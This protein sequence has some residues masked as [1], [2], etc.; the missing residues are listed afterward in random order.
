[1]KSFVILTNF[2]QGKGLKSFLQHK[3]NLG[4]PIKLLNLKFCFTIAHFYKLV[5][6]KKMEGFVTKN[7]PEK[8]IDFA[9]P[10]QYCTNT[11]LAKFPYQIS[12]EDIR[13]NSKNLD[14]NWH[15]G[16]GMGF[17]AR[18]QLVTLHHI[19]IHCTLPD[20]PISSQNPVRYPAKGVCKTLWIFTTTGKNFAL[21]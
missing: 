14:C 15:S 11:F 20:V 7:I 9:E 19:R 4:T 21:F 2:I 8:C 5:C 13:H 3:L 12:N 18:H 10:K 16:Y 1:M 17:F 6:F